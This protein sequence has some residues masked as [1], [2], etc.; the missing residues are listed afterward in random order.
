M[1]GLG[2]A[3]S[4]INHTT[5]SGSP[6]ITTSAMSCTGATAIWMAS[7]SGSGAVASDSS[8]NTWSVVGSPGGGQ[9]VVWVAYSAN[10]SASQTFTLTGVTGLG[11]Q[12]MLV[13]CWGGGSFSADVTS[14]YASASSGSSLQPG[15]ITPT[16]NGDLILAFLQN[17]SGSCVSVAIDSGFTI[18]DI[19]GAA[20]LVDANLTQSTAAAI[21]PTWSGIGIFSIPNAAAVQTAA[22]FNSSAAPTVYVRASGPAA[23]L[24]CGA[25]NATPIVLSTCA[26]HGFSA[27]CGG[28]STCYAAVEGVATGLGVS[29]AN[30]IREAH[31]V[32]ATHL[33]L[34]DLTNTAIAGTGPY[35]STT[36]LTGIPASLNGPAGAW[37]SQLTALTTAFEPIGFLDGSSGS[38]MRRLALG[39]ANGLTTIVVSGGSGSSCASV[40]CTVTVT[41]SYDPTA[42]TFP[43]A[44]GQHFSVNGT[45]T[46]LDTCG[47]GS[48]STGVQASYTVASASS[49]GWVS[50]TFTCAGLTTGDKTNVNLAC[51]P[52]AT[53]NGTIGGTQSCT[54]L[55]L[56]AYKGNAWWSGGLTTIADCH[57]IWDGGTHNPGS[58]FA[59][60]CA[61]AAIRFMVNPTDATAL[62]QVVYAL[63]NIERTGGVSF[64]INEQAGV[65][66]S[67]NDLTLYDYEA[68][69][70]L[71]NAGSTYLASADL[72][73]FRNKIYNDLDDPSVSACS[74]ALVDESDPTTHTWALS[75][76]TLA[77]GSD[78][79]HAQL[80]VTDPHYSTT[81]YYQNAVIGL[82]NNSS[83]VYSDYTY[84][85]ITS[86]SNTGLLTITPSWTT[87]GNDN[88]VSGTY[89]SGLTATGITG[90]TCGI[91][92]GGNAEASVALT[93]LNTIA[94]GTALKVLA[95]GSG[96]TTGSS[97]QVND[98]RIATAVCTGTPVVAIVAGTPYTI[99]DTVTI[100]STTSGGTATITFT[101][102]ASLSGSINVG[103]GI[104]GYNGWG[105]N[106]TLVPNESMVT[107]VGT[108][109]L[110][111]TNGSGVSAS[112]TPSMAWRMPKWTAGD[113]GSVWAMKHI[114]FPS[115]GVSPIVYPFYGGA[116]LTGTF[117]PEG[118]NMGGNGNATGEMALDLA[119][120]AE[121]ARAIR[122]L[123]KIQSYSFD[124][125]WR[126]YMDYSGGWQHSG[127]GYSIDGVSSEVHLQTWVLGNSVPTYPTV[128]PTGPWMQEWSLQKM[129]EFLPYK[130]SGT[131]FTMGWGAASS[132][133]FGAFGV[134]T[135][136]ITFD[137]AFAYAP[138]STNAGYFRNWLENINSS[139]RWGVNGVQSSRTSQALLHNWPGTPSV[140]FT[141]MPLQR[142]FNTSSSARCI[143]LTGWPCNQIRGDALISRSGWT[144]DY[145]SIAFFDFR[146]FAGDYDQPQ[147]SVRF[148]KGGPLLAPDAQF[149]GGLAQNDNTAILADGYQFAGTTPTFDLFLNFPNTSTTR[150]IFIS[151]A[152][153]AN[154][155]Y[156]DP[157][158]RYAGSC[159]DMAPAYNSAGLGIT[160]NY[161]E[162]CA[163]HFKVPGHDEFVIEGDI[164]KVGSTT[165]V[166]K[167]L[168]YS[169][170]GQNIANGI[171]MT[172]GTTTCVDASISPVSCVAALDANRI[173]K[174]VEDGSG[175]SP[176]QS[177]GL[178]SYISSPVSIK[179][180]WDCP[181][182]GGNAPQCTPS[183]KY[184]GG[185]GYSDRITIQAGSTIGGN[186]APGEYPWCVVHKIMQTLTDTTFV[187][188]AVNP[189]ANWVGC[190][191]T[192]ATSTAISLFARGNST[193]GT[194][195]NFT[196]VFSGPGDWLVSGLLPGTYTVTVASVP[197]TGSPFAVVSGDNS[198]FFSTSGGGAFALSQNG[199][200]GGVFLGGQVTF[201]GLAH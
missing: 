15:S 83:N 64:N 51:G 149:S 121:D 37:I 61:P 66:I 85:Q 94:G 68:I 63:K 78:S 153:G 41:T 69:S 6:N 54:R 136:G 107:A 124:W 42:G 189:D 31:Y 199:G 135:A 109:T 97:S 7:S 151:H 24:V 194:I 1:S 28:G 72:A 195:T 111:V 59:Y 113:C 27:S 185:N 162:I 117:I 58:G 13:Q 10:V 200:V 81:N 178:M 169:Q 171:P 56:L 143:S 172:T 98:T 36:Y 89:T 137:G 192:G 173:I 122:D 126:H 99:Y 60:T 100:N 198:I 127:P 159:Y 92:I 114:G 105:N 70:L 26:A 166:A 140:A 179:L 9:L 164:P 165:Q 110:T 82:K 112:A 21:N 30:G 2:K 157:S 80:P 3:Q 188:F 8:G 76:G 193:H 95:A 167:H 120:A 108:N 118:G 150:N 32:D 160:I 130:S 48:S 146:T 17:V 128:D 187:P 43:L 90:Q 4:L 53:P 180:N 49:S 161:A 102:T 132:Y 50:N 170:N 93:G 87:P 201:T 96:L 133:D 5:A 119:I 131:A 184:S 47:D 196:Q 73:T 39:P 75:S 197:V 34:Y 71:Y 25:T 67:N 91:Q 175:T 86:Q 45:G 191:A 101:K 40:A 57:T 38:L 168:H 116:V 14:T 19:A 44:P 46:T 182:T 174:S 12:Q 154:G 158:N 18:L 142:L 152:G 104:M 88:L 115:Y 29:P 134:L 129:L 148:Q 65:S 20:C 141:G 35:I 183:S 144:H 155:Q 156:G 52:A 186:V 77:A 22:K 23:A 176:V 139:S 62:A 11:S 181:N 123:A 147:G 125:E 145:D 79:T 177:Y 55:S 190:G 33:S 74:K 138:L 16:V 103:D 106:F 163:D 84:R